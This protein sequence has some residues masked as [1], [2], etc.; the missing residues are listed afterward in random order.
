MATVAQGGTVPPVEFEC[1]VIGCTLGENGGRYKT[2]PI[3]GIEI[4]EALQLLK[5]HN[6]N[7]VH[8]QGVSVEHDA[9]GARVGCKAE[10]APRPVLKKGQSEDE[11]PALRQAVGE[12]QASVELGERSADKRSAAG[13]L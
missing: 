8:A 5:I 7:H 3:P 12:I 2:P 1:P 6:Q 9:A 13:L 10:K 11:V 4:G